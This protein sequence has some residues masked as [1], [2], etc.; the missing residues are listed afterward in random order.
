[1]IFKKEFFI[2]TFKNKK[3]IIKST[4]CNTDVQILITEINSFSEHEIHV[5]AFKD[6][7]IYTAIETKV[8]SF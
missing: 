8:Q 5:L 4:Q 1:M 7:L 2:A 6:Y 3:E